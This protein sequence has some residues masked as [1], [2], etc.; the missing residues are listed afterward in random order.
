MP[1]QMLE[2][3]AGRLTSFQLREVVDRLCMSHFLWL[4][5]QVAT[6]LTARFDGALTHAIDQAG[7]FPALFAFCYLFKSLLNGCCINLL[8]F[9]RSLHRAH[10]E[11]LDY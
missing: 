11:W 8:F 5:L 1:S 9:D 7:V 10:D 4:Q 6:D 3:G 2:I